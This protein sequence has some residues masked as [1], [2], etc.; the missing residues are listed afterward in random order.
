MLNLKCK[1]NWQDE[2]YQEHSG[3]GVLASMLAALARVSMLLLCLQ[4]SLPGE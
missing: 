1:V 3:L 4:A 2:G